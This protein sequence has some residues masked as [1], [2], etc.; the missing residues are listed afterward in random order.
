[1][2]VVRIRNHNSTF[3]FAF[4]DVRINIYI[5]S[6]SFLS[7]QTK[8]AHKKIVRIIFIMLL[9]GKR[10]EYI[11][12]Q[13][14]NISNLLLIQKLC[15]F[16]NT[17]YRVKLYRILDCDLYKYKISERLYFKSSHGDF[18]FTGKHIPDRIPMWYFYK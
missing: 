4:N 7:S 12:W 1:V 3:I 2:L 14:S 18:T 10:V 11:C 16:R 13:Q 9:L 15:W 8:S 17:N 6:V 5:F